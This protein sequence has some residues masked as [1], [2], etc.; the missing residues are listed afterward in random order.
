MEED[1]AA[2][3]DTEEPSKITT[4]IFYSITSTQKGLQGIDLGNYLIK[5]VVKELQSEFPGIYQF[6]SLSPI[7]GFKDWLL[8]ELNQHLHVEDLC[9][10][11][12]NPL[13]LDSEID[14]ICKVTNCDHSNVYNSF[15]KILANHEWVSK[16]HICRALQ[17]ILVRLCCRY[18]YAEKRR[19]YA[20]NPVTNFH[21]SNGATLWRVNWLSDM[22]MRGIN[23]SCG[24][25]VN[26]RYF[27]DNTT[28]NSKRYLEDNFITASPEII[29]QAALTNDSQMT[30]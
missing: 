21:L 6:S 2:N 17:S 8:V 7:P 3:S 15:K 12:D 19:G 1:L 30:M 16:E 26:Y 18:L 27:L 29:E 23:Q 11:I 22:S 14:T 5:K 28:E 25:M 10:S 24:I 20:L 4:A 13:L 9:E